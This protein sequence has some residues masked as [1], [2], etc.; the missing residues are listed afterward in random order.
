MAKSTPIPSRA[1]EFSSKGP[2]GV[3]E[4]TLSPEELEEIRQKY[5]ATKADKAFKKPVA[6]QNRVAMTSEEQSRR[7]NMRYQNHEEEKDMGGQ[8][9]S[10]EGPSCGLTKKVFLEQIA[11]GETVSSI[12][13]AWGMKYNT[14]YNWV[15]NWDCKGITPGKARELLAQLNTGEPA[16]KAEPPKETQLLRE[17]E[18]LPDVTDPD[19]LVKAKKEIAELREEVG[20]WRGQ[21][22]KAGALASKAA[23]E[24][25]AKIELSRARAEGAEAARRASELDLEQASET[26]GLLRLELDQTTTSREEYKSLYEEQF[27]FAQTY[28]KQL[29]ELQSELNWLIT[30]RGEWAERELCL[31]DEIADLREGISANP[32]TERGELHVLDGAIADLTRARKLIKLLTASGE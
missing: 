32:V 18:A 26:I 24:A 2:S 29:E 20:H 10:K 25:T 15:K 13:K 6:Q 31:L 28:F 4:Y 22:D 27:A 11:A 23:E 3:R 5:P 30:K 14:L 1:I 8:R 19:L 12:E 7:A 16:P 9:A 21:A 17:K